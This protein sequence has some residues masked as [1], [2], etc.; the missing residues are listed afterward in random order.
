MCL[1]ADIERQFEF[2]LQNW[3]NNLALCGLRDE[4]DPLIGGADSTAACPFTIPMLPAPARIVAKERFVAIQGGQY[5]FLP[6]F[7]GLE[8]LA[9]TA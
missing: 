4:F 6:G 9:K 7:R 1:N 2:I 8:H 3:V 5:F